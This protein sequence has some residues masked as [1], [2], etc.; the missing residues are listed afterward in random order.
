MMKTKML[1]TLKGGS[2]SLVLGVALLSSPAY[3]QTTDAT[4]QSDQTSATT[5]AQQ[6]PA[7][8]P[9]AGAGEII[10]TGS[11]VPRPNLENVSPVTV[12]SGEQFQSTGTTR[13]ED[14]LNEMPSVF[15][16]QGSSVSNAATGTATINLRNL[17]ANRTLVLI[18]GRRLVPGDPTDSAADVNFIPSALI[19]RV[20]VLTGGASSTYGADA[21]GGVVNFVMDTDFTGVKLDAQYG[22]YQHENGAGSGVRGALND[23]DIGYPDGNVAD[24]GTVDVTGVMGAGFDDDRGHITAYLGY[25]KIKAVTQDNRDYSACALQSDTAGALSCGGSATSQGGTFLTSGNANNTYQTGQGRNFI[26]G[27]T[28]YNYAPTNY[29]QRPDERY[30]AGFFADYEV[31]DAFHPYMEGMFMDDRTVAQI[32]PSGDF[33]NTFSINCDN[34]LL[35]AQQQAIVCSPTNM[36]TASTDPVTGALVAPPSMTGGAPDVVGDGTLPAY[37]FI[38]PTTG[39]TYNR[40]AL[41][42]L[43]RN[44]EGGPRQDDLQHTSYRIVAGARGDIGTGLSYDAYYQY[45]RTNFSETYFN[46]FSINRLGRALD[47]VTD[48]T[49]GEAVCRTALDGTDP[50]CVPYDIFTQGGVSDA[51]VNY[52]TT[53]G[54]Q[55]AQVEE[56]VASATMTALLGEYGVISPWSDEGVGINVGAEYRKEALNLDTDTAFQTGDLA[57]QGAATLPV[58]GSFRVYEAFGE[59]RLP[60]VRDSFIYDFTLEGGYRYSH[61]EVGDRSFNTDTYKVGGELAPVQGVRFRGSYNRAVRSPNIQEF[62]APQRVALNGSTDPCAGFDITAADTGCIAQGLEVG[63]N[64]IPNPSEQYNGLIGGNPDLTPEKS[65]TYTVG[66]VIEPSFI[67]A[68]NGFSLTVDYFNIKV[69]NLVSQIGQDTILNQCTNDPNSPFCDLINRDSTGS[70]WRSPNGYVT[71][72]TQ[73]IG[74]LKTA[75]VDVGANYAKELGSLGMLSLSFNGTWL[76]SYEVND[77]VSTPYDCVGYYGNQCGTPIPEWRH[78]LYASFTLPDGIG[79]TAAWRYFGPVHV[80]ASSDNPTLSGDFSQFNRRIG[81][82]SYFDLTLTASIA[83]HYQFRLGVQNLLDRDPPLVSSSACPAGFCNG[84]TYPVVYDALG[85]YIFTGVTLNF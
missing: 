32:A 2:A 69:K 5:P 78:R 8:S 62:F 53:P 10:V 37:D 49:T 66:V 52:L 22:F 31:S 19:E 59:A 33:G 3:A 82:Q 64:I 84:N 29:Y 13:V 14:L 55:R 43:R 28:P 81:S 40:G 15:A 6:E 48:P 1:Q 41:Q 51:A 46:D 65:D 85:R 34:P 24:G 7:A 61:Y 18:N 74:S 20:D 44:V 16:D 47:V 4:Q 54:F 83:E 38:D 36:V 30:T 79:L 42:I 58:N 11:R 72:L 67:E 23:A 70:L 63:D 17:G 57:G 60:I 56:Q 68:L 71:D 75:G 45:G 26:P 73:N 12:V 27:Y 9:P 50:N 21:V 80:D 39:A 76:D 25:R 77:G 35:S